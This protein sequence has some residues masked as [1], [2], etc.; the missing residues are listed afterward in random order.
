MVL[1][2]AKKYIPLGDLEWS[3]SDDLSDYTVNNAWFGQVT[4]FEAL[5]QIA[6]CLFWQGLL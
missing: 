4:Y 1:D 6:K 2:S 5:S 3:I